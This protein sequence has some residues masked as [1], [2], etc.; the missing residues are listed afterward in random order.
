MKSIKLFA[1]KNIEIT[2]Q[3][4]SQFVTIN[5]ELYKT[6]KQI[7]MKAINKMISV[8]LNVYCCYLGINLT[9]DENKKIGDIFPHKEKVLIK[10]ILPNSESFI[11]YS[12]TRRT[13]SL[14]K[15][16]LNDMK[17][18]NS[19]FE[20]NNNN[21]NTFFSSNN[22]NLNNNINSFSPKLDLLSIKSTR[23]P[24]KIKIIDKVPKAIK[25]L[26][27]LSV[28]HSNSQ[29][30][31]IFPINSLKENKPLLALKMNSDNSSEGKSKKVGKL[32]GCKKYQISEYCRTC[33]KFICNECRISDKHKN[34][35]NIHLDMFN[36]KNNILSYA[37]LVQKDIM[38]T[39][40]LNK[41]IRYNSFDENLNYKSYKDEINEKYEKAIE[42]YFQVIN[43]IN[44]YILKLD[45]ERT[46]LQIETYNKN[47]IK[48]R[49]EIDDLMVKFKN[50]KNKEINLNYIEYYF[51]EINSREEM[52]LFLQK[53]ILKY[54][55]S[56][57]INIKMKSSLNKIDKILNEINN[58]KNPFNLGD[59]YHNEFV[60]MKIIVKSDNEKEI[61]PKK[62]KNKD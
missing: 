10:L 62:G 21:T 57:E 23:K 47:S 49:N 15:H 55:L 34:H 5:S 45:P 53:D 43:T 20:S 11:N 1:I 14:Y 59:K 46:K 58:I 37:N 56:H 54:H 31:L 33:G 17:N 52:L 50:N 44:N 13:N 4:L 60:N 3:Y 32:C 25:F 8:P 18:F 48:I 28:K 40:E 9:K 29:K 35:L 30:D 61:V 7:K 27:I 16:E 51:N 38:G 12:I 26:N 36:L 22:T 19:N 42:K 24:R 2:F 6:L 39:L 41:N